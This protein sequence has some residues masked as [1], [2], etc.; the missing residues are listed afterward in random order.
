ML[1]ARSREHLFTGKQLKS[2]APFIHGQVN[3]ITRWGYRD[4][5][6]RKGDKIGMDYTHDAVG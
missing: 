1:A 4:G 6:K 3:Q 2:P 5:V